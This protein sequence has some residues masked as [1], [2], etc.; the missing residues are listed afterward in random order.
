VS[1]TAT[2]PRI[3]GYELREAIGRGGMASVYVGVEIATHE[4]VAVKVLAQ[5]LSADE[6]YKARFLR[7]ARLHQSLRHPNISRVLDYGES[8]AGCYLVTEFLS[9]GDLND[10]LHRGMHLQALI[11][12]IKDMARALHY[13]HAVGV[14]HRDIKPENILFRTDGTAVLTDFG[15]ADKASDEPTKS[16]RGTVVGTPEYMSPEQAAG[17][18]LDGRSDL[19]SLGV[20][21]YR[22]LTGDL[23]FRAET[24]V[25][26]ALKHHQDP[27][28]RLPDYLHAFQPIIDKL[29]AKKP[30][31]RFDNGEELVDALDA[32]RASAAMP[33]ATIK[34][35][36]I[37]TREIMAV[38]GDLLSTAPDTVR[39]ERHTRRRKRRRQLR[40][41]A[42]FLLIAG[43]SG[44]AAYYAYEQGWLV[45]EAVLA[46]LGMGEDPRLAVAWS[47]AQS[48]RQDPN[49][50]LATIVA[51]YR[52]VLAIDPDHQGAQREVD[53]LVSDWKQ[54]INEA[55]RQGNLESAQTR[56]EEASAAFPGDVQ[57]VQLNVELQNRFR[58][59]RIMVSAQ[60][61]LTSNGMSDLPSATAAIQSFQEVLRLA[62]ENRAAQ[63]ALD[64]IAVHYAEL[65]STAANAGEVASAINLLERASA[66][67]ATLT[68][69]DEVR[70]LISQATTAQAAINDLLQQA[71]RYRAEN[72]LIEPPGANAA[73]LYHRV[74]ATD[75]GNVIATQGLDE[76]T[77]QITTRVDQLLASGQL[78]EVSLVVTKAASAGMSEV[79]INDIRSRLDAEQERLERVE[80]NLAK[81]R[82][83]MAQGY[84]TAPAQ[85]NAVA[86]LREVQQ[87]DPG[88]A[89]AQALLEQCA[90]RLAA[91]AQEAHEF[92][93][94]DAA[95]QYLD[96]ALTITPEMADW[97]ALR[98]SW[99]GQARA[100]SERDQ[101]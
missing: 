5:K 99:E 77:S 46:Q 80:N 71:R 39:Q 22:M 7:G 83:L 82:R 21:L 37:S 34:T 24:A 81:A 31:Q 64:D 69:L 11:K 91:V 26:V 86:S 68:E 88:N 84:L 56:L 43:T 2:I 90:Q 9:G 52:R 51:G 4:Q 96:L 23:P 30:E 38:G 14:I 16:A 44:G 10:R 28:P 42:G 20:V 94:F 27:I 25:S 3:N 92:G 19:Y 87:L 50:G 58:A 1:E 98:D 73:E 72:Q 70:R 53:S 67:N 57:W 12:V 54:S 32:L 65:A 48:L 97:V 47:E 62:P 60:A 100:Q 95:E 45:P 8:P 33:E 59:E 89:T 93:L 40:L 85:N 76:V 78:A 29:L 6:D 35:Q 74:L 63:Q 66:A 36:P 17:R 18:P 79:V 49:Q 15:I 101:S 13:A 55:L 41:A 61:L 75:P